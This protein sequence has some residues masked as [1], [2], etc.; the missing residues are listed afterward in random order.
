VREGEER[1][2]KNLN[3]LRCHDI[4]KLTFLPFPSPFFSFSY[5]LCAFDQMKFKIEYYLLY[6]SEGERM[7]ESGRD[8][9]TLWTAVRERE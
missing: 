4:M 1:R 5:L 3:K 7:S 6:Y 2:E 9:K 8:K